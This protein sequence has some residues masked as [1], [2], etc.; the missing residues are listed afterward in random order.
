MAK[1]FEKMEKELRNEGLDDD[2]AQKA[3]EVFKANLPPPVYKS[4]IHYLGSATILL[5][6]GSIA[7]YIYKGALPD[8]IWGAIGAGIGGL[9][10]LFMGSQ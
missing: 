3:M 10:G 6:F 7:M 8:A 5:V 2:V 1:R 4:A 9:A